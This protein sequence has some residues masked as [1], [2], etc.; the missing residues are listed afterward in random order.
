MIIESLCCVKS[1]HI[2]I[3][4]V[5]L[6]HSKHLP[7]YVVSVDMDKPIGTFVLPYID[8]LGLRIVSVGGEGE[9]GATIQWKVFGQDVRPCPSE[10]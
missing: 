8:R 1:Y 4:T 6:H 5:S 10:L 3:I 2:T 9:F 7:G